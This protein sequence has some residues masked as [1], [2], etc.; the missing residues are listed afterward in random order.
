MTT[1]RLCSFIYFYLITFKLLLLLLSDWLHWAAASERLMSWV[2]SSVWSRGWVGRGGNWQVCAGVV[3]AGAGCLSCEP[4]LSIGADWMNVGVKNGLQSEVTSGALRS[5]YRAGQ[6]WYGPHTQRRNRHGI[7][8]ESDHLR[9]HLDSR[10]LGLGDRG[11]DACCCQGQLV[12]FT[13]Y[14]GT[15]SVRGTHGRTQHWRHRGL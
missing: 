7:T 5:R 15:Y 6:G 8:W 11:W 4:V 1:K 3:W 9:Q 2:W 10:D 13:C 14:H 12:T